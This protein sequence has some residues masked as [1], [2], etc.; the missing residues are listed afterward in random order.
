MLSSRADSG[1]LRQ[2]YHK[3]RIKTTEAAACP[4][5]RAEFDAANIAD[6]CLCGSHFTIRMKWLPTPD[7]I[8]R[9]AKS[10]VNEP[11]TMFFGE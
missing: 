8:R 7:E 1:A 6:Y 5:G 4:V 11:K 10:A 9:G 3:E 2:L